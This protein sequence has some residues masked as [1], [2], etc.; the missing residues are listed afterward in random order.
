MTEVSHA[1]PNSEKCPRCGSNIP[2]RSTTQQVVCGKCGWSNKPR[3]NSSQS[4]AQE[5]G[6][7]SIGAI[8]LLVL[9][10]AIFVWAPYQLYQ[11]WANPE[12]RHYADGTHDRQQEDHSSMA[13]VM[14]N[15]FVKDRLIAPSTA[16]FP[17]R[18]EV[19]RKSASIYRVSSYVDAQNSFGAK[20]RQNYICEVQRDGENWKL[21]EFE[22]AG[23]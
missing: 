15:D 18:Q 16:E 21:I 2:P 19:I 5:Q 8:F 11:N 3:S 22:M 10:L 6:T 13:S 20:L 14:C 17:L 1:R 4:S 9:G 7:N 12:L 23:R